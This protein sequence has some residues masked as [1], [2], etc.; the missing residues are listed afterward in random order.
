MALEHIPGTVSGVRESSL[1]GEAGRGRSIAESITEELDGYTLAQV[2][3]VKELGRRDEGVVKKRKSHKQQYGVKN[4][5]SLLS[6]ET[7]RS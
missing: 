6:P 5:Q 7:G 3:S 4:R 2:S 1:R